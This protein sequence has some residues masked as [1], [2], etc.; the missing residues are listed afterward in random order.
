MPNGTFDD[1]RDAIDDLA[2]AVTVGRA[3][4]ESAV[5]RRDGC[6][7][8]VGSFDDAAACGATPTAGGN[9][10]YRYCERHMQMVSDAGA[11]TLQWDDARVVDDPASPIDSDAPAS[12]HGAS[13]RVA[14]HLAWKAHRRTILRMREQLLH[15][16]DETDRGTR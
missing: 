9:G 8:M 1:E 7:M 10:L 13:E 12:V 16:P 6:A 2:L 4:G 3:N 15:D 5:I 11:T 14:E